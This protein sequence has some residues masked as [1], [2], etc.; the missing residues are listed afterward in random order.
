MILQEKVL[1]SDGTNI[2]N[3]TFEHS[4]VS[5]TTKKKFYCDYPNCRKYFREK[6]N[7]KTHSRIHVKGYVYI[8]QGK[9]RLNA[10]LQDAIR[11][12]MHR[13]TSE[14]MKKDI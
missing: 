2:D 6:G 4:P 14:T 12:S 9:S 7:L 10:V 5:V 8:R 13:G 3:F 1:G 11:D